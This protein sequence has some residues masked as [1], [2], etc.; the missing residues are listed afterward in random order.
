MND[1]F[2]HY[3]N[4]PVPLGCLHQCYFT[5]PLSSSTSVYCSRKVLHKFHVI[6]VH[7]CS[8]KT[9]LNTLDRLFNRQHHML[10]YSSRLFVN[11]HPKTL[12]LLH[13]PYKLL[14]HSSFLI[15]GSAYSSNA[16]LKTLHKTFS[17]IS[18]ISLL[19]HLFSRKVGVYYQGKALIRESKLILTLC[20]H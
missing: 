3:H 5:I 13:P 8:W 20:Y 19:Y 12:L 2:L 17:E 15:L 14:Y 4:G 6:Y 9:H 16:I 11:P 1:F 10:I 18:Q 7:L